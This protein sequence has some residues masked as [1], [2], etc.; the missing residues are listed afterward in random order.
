MAYYLAFHNNVASWVGSVNHS[1]FKEVLIPILVSRKVP[2]NRIR[3]YYQTVDAEVTVAMDA[4]RACDAENQAEPT[5]HQMGRR[6]RRERHMPS[7]VRRKTYV[8]CREYVSIPLS[9]R[10]SFLS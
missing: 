1:F 8:S 5:H 4:Q 6:G 10:E 3:K 2:P 9:A 7:I